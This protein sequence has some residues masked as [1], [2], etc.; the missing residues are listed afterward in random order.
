MEYKVE[1]SV[2]A[3][4][5]MKAAYNW[6]E[7]QKT[8]LG[9]QFIYVI[10][11]YFDRIKANPE[12]YSLRRDNIRRCVVKPFP[13]LILYYVSKDFYKDYFCIFTQVEIHNYK[14]AKSPFYQPAPQ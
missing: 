7:K 3:S 2:R 5:N 12:I 14:F 9:K 10:Q 8:G 13:F 1:L 4:K 6:Y 11:R